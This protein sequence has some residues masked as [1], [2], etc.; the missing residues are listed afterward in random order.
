MALNNFFTQKLFCMLFNSLFLISLVAANPPARRQDQSGPSFG[1]TMGHSL[2]GGVGVGAGASVGTMAVNGVASLF[3]RRRGSDK[4]A[5]QNQSQ[6]GCTPGVPV[7]IASPTGPLKGIWTA[8]C[9]IA[10]IA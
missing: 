7:T 9:S 8:D 6:T 1:Q 10:Q 5:E 2:L 3:H 4:V